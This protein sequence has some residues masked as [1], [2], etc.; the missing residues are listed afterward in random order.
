MT[1]AS[2]RAKAAPG[3]RNEARRDLGLLKWL[4]IV[5]PLLFLGAA[6]FV[7]QA[8]FPDH[9]YSPASRVFFFAGLAIAI[10]V[11]SHTVFGA[12][13]RLQGRMLRQ[14]ERLAALN[15]IAT[16][17]AETPGLQPLLDVGLEQVLAVLHADAGLIC[18]VDREHGEHTAVASRGF[19]RELVQSIQRAR[20]CDDPVACEVVETGRPVMLGH[21]LD[22]PRFAAVA[23]RE[24][25]RSSISVPLKSHGDV[26]GVMAVASETE[27]GFG[28]EERELLANVGGQLGMAIR[29][30][31]VFDR[32]LQRNRELEALLTV[33][34]AVASSLDFRDVL[35]RASEAMLEVTSAEAVEIWLAD[36]D[37]VLTLAHHCGAEADTFHTAARF[38]SGEGLPGLALERRAPVVVHD[39]ARDPRFRNASV[40]AAGFHSYCAL[41]LHHR[42]EPLGVLG[43][44]GRAPHALSA[45]DE[46]RLLAGMGEV[47]SVAIENARLYERVQDKAV[48][49]ERERIAREMHDGLAQVLTYVNAQ[50]LAIGKLLAAGS[51]REAQ[52]ELALMEDAVQ[53]VYADVREAILGLR[54]APRSA[55]GLLPSIRRYAESF[56]EMTGIP[57]RLDVGHAAAAPR[58]SSSTEIQLTRILQEALS[59]VR[60]HARASTVTVRL[61]LEDGTLRLLIADDGQG[62]DPGRLQPRGW[63]RFG[64]QTMRERAGAVGGAFEILSGSGVGTTVVVEV[65]LEQA[66]TR[67][68]RAIDPIAA[69]A[70]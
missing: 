60:K 25:I 41:P 15:A 69:G 48:I 19:S 66:A 24:G 45:P 70:A 57:T 1:D 67:S 55:G 34:G 22:D 4:A 40:R 53:A 17:A 35:G 11:F 43:V 63:P 62:F 26:V 23:E 2:P 12:I 14:N 6:D 18:T 30:A 37:G 7:R 44:A 39:V 21:L 10:S 33:S 20:L 16:A 28:D 8:L 27:R 68:R 29:H 38:R 5:L 50:S 47:I 9:F 36:D 46:L 31:V 54:T 42:E 65:E 51:L 49:E 56:E 52:R 58:L 13:A 32:S 59:N 61:E 64:L 3:T